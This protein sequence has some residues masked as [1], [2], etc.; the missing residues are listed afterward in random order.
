MPVESA[1]D[2]IR[3]TAEEA[4]QAVPAS[5]RARV[6]PKRRSAGQSTSHLASISVVAGAF[7]V[8]LPGLLLGPVAV[9]CGLLALCSPGEV[10]Q[11]AQRNRAIL[12][13]L[14]GFL[15]FVA[16]ALLV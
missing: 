2:P 12:G 1:T 3:I 7:G 15:D 4:W 11:P 9:A 13:V 14:L 8:L 5:P 16:W 10:S 6:E